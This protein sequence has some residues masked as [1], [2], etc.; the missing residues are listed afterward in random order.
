MDKPVIKTDPNTSSLLFTLIWL[1]GDF[2]RQM[3]FPSQATEITLKGTLSGG[4]VPYGLGS[5]HLTKGSILQ[6]WWHHLAAGPELRLDRCL[7]LEY[8]S[9]PI[10]VCCVWEAWLNDNVQIQSFPWSRDRFG[11]PWGQ[12]TLV[13]YQ[14]KMTTEFKLGGPSPDGPW[15]GFN[16][17]WQPALWSLSGSGFVTVALWVTHSV[18]LSFGFCCRRI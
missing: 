11:L 16:V 2:W 8:V 10:S 7:P 14:G 18:S 1:N 17:G 13:C 12:S 4:K 15:D 6:A 9:A 5:L 3:L